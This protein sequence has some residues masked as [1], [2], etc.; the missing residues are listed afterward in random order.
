VG[1]EKIDIDRGGLY[2]LTILNTTLL[3]SMHV[4]FCKYSL[5]IDN[6]FHQ[7]A[8][9]PVHITESL[10]EEHSWEEGSKYLA[11]EEKADKKSIN[12]LWYKKCS[13]DLKQLKC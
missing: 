4:A 6:L 1:V 2:M 10:H 9:S 5:Q 7:K 11:I 8:T 3:R 12:E 13:N